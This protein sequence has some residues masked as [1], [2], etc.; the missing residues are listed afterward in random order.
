MTDEKRVFVAYDERAAYDVDRASV[1][2]V[3]NSLEEVKEEGRVVYSYR[4]SADAVG[5]PAL[6]NPRLEYPK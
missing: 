1:I 2:E 3:G 5:N 6:V 4:Q